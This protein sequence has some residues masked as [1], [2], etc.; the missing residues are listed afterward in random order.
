MTRTSPDDQSQ[1]VIT[2]IF[3][4]TRA[5]VFQCWISPASVPLWWGPRGFE[6][7]TCSIDAR[8][9]G[10]WRVASRHE[11][12][13]ETAETGVIRE[14]EAPSRLVLTHAWETPDRR[15]GVET[16]VT[17]TFEDAPGGTRMTFRQ[18]GL[19]SAASRDGHTVGWN[20][21][22]DMLAEHLA[23]SSTEDV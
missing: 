17:I 15:P 5:R 22:F 18:T 2:R 10:T 11:D 9:G 13:S 20:E 14:I 7:L 3:D 23:R 6:T 21:S 8:R 1:L 19:E 4:A 16:V 12:G